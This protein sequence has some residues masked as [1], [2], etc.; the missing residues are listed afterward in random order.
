MEKP[1]GDQIIITEDKPAKPDVVVVVPESEKKTEKK[2]VT[3]K[4]TI[5]ERE[6]D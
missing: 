4:T 6:A 5:V 2:I 3:E 1:M